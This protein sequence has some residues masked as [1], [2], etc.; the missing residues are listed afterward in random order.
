MD[1]VTNIAP[2]F[3]LSKENLSTRKIE[4]IA[5]AGRPI[6][7][8]YFSVYGSAPL[9]VVSAAGSWRLGGDCQRGPRLRYSAPGILHNSDLY[10]LVT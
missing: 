10:E 9:Q 1:T 2:I 3:L 6:K 5:M 7:T 8:H 4:I